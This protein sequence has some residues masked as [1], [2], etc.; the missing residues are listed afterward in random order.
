MNAADPADV[1]KRV[2]GMSI[3]VRLALSLKQGK[4]GVIM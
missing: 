2:D 1:P 4:K 3:G